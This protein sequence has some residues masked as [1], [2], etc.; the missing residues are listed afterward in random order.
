MP[1]Y[2]RH[3]ELPKYIQYTC[4]DES[5]GDEDRDRRVPLYAHRFFFSFQNPI[6]VRSGRRLPPGSNDH[7]GC[8]GQ[9]AV[10]VGGVPCILVRVLVCVCVCVCRG[11]IIIIK[12]TH[13]RIYIIRLIQYYRTGY[14]V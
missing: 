14:G 12:N 10:V 6:T 5:G 13:T 7:V 2:I 9:T 1:M 11:E 8:D 3:V 4:G